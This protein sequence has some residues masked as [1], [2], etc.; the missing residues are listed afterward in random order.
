MYIHTNKINNKVYIGQTINANNPQN[1]WEHGNGYQQVPL[2]YKAIQEFGWDNF[3]HNILK[4]DLTKEEADYW[5]KYYIKQYN[6][7]NEAFGYNMKKGGQPL[8]TIPE[9]E[10]I[11]IIDTYIECGSVVQTSILTNHNQRV[12]SRILKN[13]GF[14]F[15]NISP[16]E[17]VDLYN[18]KRSIKEV[19]EI[20]NH[21][22]STIK[23]ILDE[24]G[25]EI[26]YINRKHDIEYD[27]IMKIIQRYNDGC[28]IENIAN[29]F[30]FKYDFITPYYVTK[31]LKINGI[32]TNRFLNQKLNVDD[33]A[34]KYYE[35]KSIKATAKCFGVNREQLRLYMIEHNIKI[36]SKNIK[37]SIKCSF[38]NKEIIFDSIMEC[39]KYLIDNEIVDN[40]CERGL[41]DS[42]SKAMKEHTAYKKIKI[43]RIV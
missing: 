10:E 29:E 38:D 6:S 18:Q 15:S 40:K 32:N 41:R 11:K 28:S 5:E 7:T 39:A 12:V 36:D 34:N 22:C 35:T 24:H 25:I 37:M 3:S 13:N 33:V 30:K 9:D 31:I 23:K 19:H 1:R 42:L 27:D 16:E 2:L 8:R 21:A 43:E 20:T 4:T 14:E 26:K 17:I